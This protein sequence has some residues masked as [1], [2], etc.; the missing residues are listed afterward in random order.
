MN[1]KGLLLI[2]VLFLISFETS[3]FAAEDIMEI[4]KSA[5]YTD[6]LEEN[7]PKASIVVD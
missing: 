1:K 7:K 6:V 2:I 4:T 3:A 5:G